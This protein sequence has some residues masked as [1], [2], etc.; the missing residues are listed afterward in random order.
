MATKKKTAKKPAGKVNK[1]MVRMYRAGT[2]DC[3]LLQFKAGATV[4]FNL[5]V[6]CGCIKGGRKDFESM[7]T[8]IKTLTKGKIDLLVVTHEH[9]DHIN[10]FE[11]CADILDTMN[12]KKVWFAWTE[13]ETDNQAN[14][15]REN[16][17]K[18]KMALEGAAMRLNGLVKDGYY[19][20][21]FADEYHSSLMVN[22]KKHF[23]SSVNQL[24][25]L[26]LNK[27]PGASGKIPSM[28]EL[29]KGFNVIKAGTEVECLEPGDLKKD[30]PGLKGI[31][32]F[33]LGPPRDY[34]KLSL[35]EK[36]G[37]TY[38]KRENP[39]SIDFAFAAAVTGEAA[40]PSDFIPFDPEH[41]LAD[42]K[43]PIRRDYT[44]SSDWRKIDYDW[45]YSAGNLALRFERSI[46]N[47]SLALAIQFEDSERVL[48]FPGDAEYG[49]WSSWHEGLEWTIKVAGKSKKVNAEYLLN[50]TVFYKIGHHCSQNGTASKKGTDM[51]THEDLAAMGTLHF[52]KI[53]T[54]WLNTM[55]NDILCASLIAKTKGK[56]FF[57]GE[58]AKILP[59]IK[60]DRVTVK[61]TH[62]TT[63]NNLNKPFDGKPFIEYEVAG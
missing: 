24:N 17:S 12:F 2:G 26:N 7:L 48:L 5:M 61:K 31:R 41:E 3:F 47:T 9:A 30:I 22:S 58:R 46:N 43:A 8:D 11:K 18:L 50:N 40:G 53:N 63:L 49:N 25:E 20:G 55:P 45:L 15:Y 60:T 51:M 1:V 56:L 28:V 13:D 54:G 35:T 39:S 6:D 37:E 57:A 52:K 4:V 33:V 59:N 32:F 62:E 42:A 34:G 21:V 36:E 19:E 27:V 16:H 44:E 23:I 10:G 29:F 38:E 14:D